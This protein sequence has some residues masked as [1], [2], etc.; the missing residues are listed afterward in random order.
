MRGWW[1]GLGV[2]FR[3]RELPGLPNELVGEAGS[4]FPG[5]GEDESEPALNGWN[6]TEVRRWCRGVSAA[7]ERRDD[8]EP[9][10]MR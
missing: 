10:A 7:A 2:T 3:L 1:S 4:A 6:E 5:A 9:W 8:L